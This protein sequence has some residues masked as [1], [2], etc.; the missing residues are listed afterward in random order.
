MGE[1]FKCNKWSHLTPLCTA[2]T[3]QKQEGKMTNIISGILSFSKFFGQTLISK[4]ANSFK[5]WK[6]K[7][8]ECSV[9]TRWFQQFNITTT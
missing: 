7:R 2:N 1:L 3:E 9:D 4:D 6:E 8:N 5:W